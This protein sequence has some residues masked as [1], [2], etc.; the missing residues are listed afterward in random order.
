MSQHEKPSRSQPAA[1]RTS[2]R[3]ASCSSCKSPSRMQK[4]GLDDLSWA[5]MLLALKEPTEGRQPASNE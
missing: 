4:L 1:E 3:L 5:M 2:R